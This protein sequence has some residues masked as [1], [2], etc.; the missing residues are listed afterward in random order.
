MKGHRQ[1]LVCYGVCN[2]VHSEFFFIDKNA[3]MFLL[4]L[5]ITERR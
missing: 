5:E 1:K 2:R 3:S 4:I